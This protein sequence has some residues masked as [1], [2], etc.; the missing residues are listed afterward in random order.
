MVAKNLKILKGMNESTPVKILIVDDHEE[1]LFAMEALLESPELFIISARSGNEALGILLEQEVALI[2]LDVQMPGMNGFETAELI[3]GSSRTRHIPIIF[4][5]AISKEKRN[6]FQGYESGAVDYLFKPIEPEILRSK[7]RVFIDL[8]QQKQTLENITR[9][10]EM[11]ISELIESRK[12]LRFNEESIREAWQAAERARDSAEEASRAKSEFLANMSHEIRTPLNGIIGMADLA[13]LET[14]NPQQKERFELIRQS[15]ESLLEILNEILDLSK[16][17]AERV[18]LETISFNPMEVVE[19]VVRML[20]IK[21]HEKNLELIC[22]IDPRIP[23]QVVG[24]PT[25][26][27][28]VMLNLVS[29]AYK[30]TE[31][32]EI[33][34]VAIFRSVIEN[35]V[36]IDISVSDTGI[37]IAANKLN[38]IFQSFEQAETSINRKYG[39]TGLGLSITKKLLDLMQG[40]IHVESILGKGSAFSL[41]IPFKQYAEPQI[42][43]EEVRDKTGDYSPVL[44]ID[45][46]GKSDESIRAVLD[47]LPMEYKI[48]VTPVID[49][50]ELIDS[51]TEEKLIII[52]SE[53]RTSKNE[54][55]AD[56]LPR[57]LK[58]T[59]NIPVIVMAPGTVSINKDEMLARGLF[60]ILRKPLFP[61]NIRAALNEPTDLNHK[62]SST[63]Q[64]DSVATPAGRSLQI[65]LAEDNPINTKL[66]VGL[67]QLRNWNVDCAVNGQEAVDMFQ[68]KSY[69]LVLMDIQMPEMDGMDAT[70]K[71]REIESMKGLKP[72]PVVALSANAMK[73][74]IDTALSFG[75]DDYITKPFKPKELF[76]IIEK[77]TQ[78]RLES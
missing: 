63:D 27:R 24:D 37:G 51:I 43:A 19:R 42:P 13:L 25:R 29:N 34:I 47:S 5:T 52:D 60:S 33:R 48:M 6:I 12:K 1:N 74:D 71:I 46:S 72:I 4:V 28:Q 16:I 49:I 59:K 7:V 57:A 38:N 14:A 10:L 44:I 54:L 21:I 65:L 69:D 2:L 36:I 61:R 56:E 66:A 15:G 9:K 70:K 75:M 58:I 22:K 67:I 73:N 41:S 39:G 78:L 32:G 62:D 35:K 20:S 26:F 55:L 64:Q 50:D 3:R 45:K 17:E 53:I 23:D 76:L 30:F 40:E 8:H 18:E 68:L 11:T 77:L 31:K